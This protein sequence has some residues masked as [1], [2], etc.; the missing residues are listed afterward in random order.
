MSSSSEIAGAKAKASVADERF[1]EAKNYEKSGNVE[2]SQEAYTIAKNLYKSSAEMYIKAYESKD[3]DGSIK[4]DVESRIE[5][6]ISRAKNS[7]IR[8]NNL[9]PRDTKYELEV[10]SSYNENDKICQIEK[11]LINFSNV[12]GMN[13][14]KEIIEEKIIRPMKYKDVFVKYGKK[15]GGK[16]LGYGAPGCG[17]TYL[18]KAAAGE[19][20][21]P[22]LS[23]KAADILS[24]YVGV[25]PKNIRKMFKEA[26]DNAPCILFI[27]EIDGL[28]KKVDGESKGY[29]VNQINQFLT[30]LDSTTSSDKL[31]GVLVLA[32]T[33]RPW[34]IDSRLIR[35][36]RFDKKIHIAPPDYEARIE[37]FKSQLKNRPFVS[38]NI[39]YETLAKKTTGYS[40]ADIMNVCEE[41]FDYPI[42]EAINSIKNK[43]QPKYREINTDDLLKT[44]DD[45][46]PSLLSWMIDAEVELGSS[47][48][49]NIYNDLYKTIKKFTLTDDVK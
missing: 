11:P 6:C 26:H 13:R 10:K 19:S 31:E 21:V 44:L 20:R 16:I 35:N 45:S 4:S 42:S 39:D 7:N 18:F 15:S 49:K 40:C 32:A 23:V 14:E 46:T 8:A 9:K 41:S 48:Q 36:G 1:K 5:Y 25:T 33:N 30:E 28:T 22:L 34:A 24:E 47:N 43:K 3:F 38:E 29:E 12:G 17:K 37:V 2:K 27:D